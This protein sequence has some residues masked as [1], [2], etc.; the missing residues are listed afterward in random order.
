MFNLDFSN[1]AAPTVHI[2]CQTVGIRTL[3]W[4]PYWSPLSPTISALSIT[5]TTKDTPKA[6]DALRVLGVE[7]DDGDLARPAWQEHD[8]AHRP[9]HKEHDPAHRPAHQEHDPAQRPA[10]QE[11]DPAHRPAHQEHNPAHRP[12]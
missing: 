8:P 11:H 3:N 7:E 6:V 2:I 9:A 12:A 1:S 5:T 10:H 4:Y